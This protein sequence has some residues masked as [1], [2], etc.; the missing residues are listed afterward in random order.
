MLRWVGAGALAVALGIP[1]NA[2]AA[3]LSV[4]DDRLDCPSAGYTS[5][6]AAVDAASPGDI[7]AICPGTYEEGPA[8]V[9]AGG[10]N[11]VSIAKMLTIRGAGAS[12]VTIRPKPT[13]GSLLG[14]TTNYRNNFG[15]VI[16]VYRA[17]VRTLVDISGVTVEGG[18]TTVGSAVKFY[19]AEGSLTSSVVRNVAPLNG[20]YGYGVVI[21]SNL[22]ADR[23]PVRVAGTSISGYA[24]AGVVLDSTQLAPALGV[25]AATITG[26]TITGAGTQVQTPQQGVLATGLVSGSITANAITNNFGAGDRASA[27]IRLVD[28]DLA[29]LTGGTTTKLTATGNN[30]VGNG[31]GVVNETGAG[32]DAALPFTATGNWW[33]NVAGPSIG[34]PKTVGDPVNGAAVNYSG[35]RTTAIT[36]P[37]TP[38]AIVDALPTGEIDPPTATSVVVPGTTYTLRAIAGDDFGVRSVTF[39]IGGVPVASDSEVPYRA[40]WTPSAA[41]EGQTVPLTVTILDSAGQTTAAPLTLNLTVKTPA[42]EPTPTPTPTPTAT[43]TATATPTPEPLA[44]PAATVAPTPAPAL[45]STAKS[46]T[47][48]TLAVKSAKRRKLTVSGALGLPQG[49]TCPAAGTVSLSFT[50]GKK[51]L[52]RASVKLDAKC[53]YTVS[54]TL[55]RTAG[56]RRVS[57]NARFLTVGT[58]LARSAPERKVTVKR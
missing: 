54:A 45:V 24:K 58:L 12:K 10:A 18:V 30:I 33:G 4:D 15:A 20:A 50:I 2:S 41:L 17:G 29:P 39:A 55:P 26:N 22:V 57:V 38:T 16:G 40:T 23:L 52:K 6:Q 47:K 43:A 51:V 48:L 25:L 11:A 1:A 21:A 32:A 35:F 13:I 56:G 36:A 37:V 9:P 27:G 53:A 5:V 34:L 14:T 31:Y 7:V 19:N 44:A 46:P 28:L 8:T 42:P 3:T 49:V